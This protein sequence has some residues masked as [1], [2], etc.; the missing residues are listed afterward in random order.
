VL[1][2]TAVDCVAD[3]H[4]RCLMEE[5]IDDTPWLMDTERKLLDILTAASCHFVCLVIVSISVTCTVLCRAAD[6]AHIIA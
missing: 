4:S 1:C 2:E 3:W 6:N 5:L